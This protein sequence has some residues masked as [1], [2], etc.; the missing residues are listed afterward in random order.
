MVQKALILALLFAAIAAGVSCGNTKSH[1]LYA[2]LPAANEIVAFREDP[3]SGVLTELDGSPYSVGDG[4]HSIVIH[5]SG[6]FAYACNPG[7]AANNENDISLF[8][9]ASNGELTEVFPRTPLGSTVSLPQ[10]LVMDPAGA[11]LYVMNAGS[12]NISIFSI[13]SS[14]GAL[15]QVPNSPVNIGLTPL[16]MQVTSNGKLLYVTAVGTNITGEIVG[17]SV[18]AG[19]LTLV[20]VTPSGGL[21]PAGLVIDPAGAHLYAGNNAASSSSISIFD[22]GSTGSLTQVAGSPLNDSNYSSPIWMTFD[23]NGQYLYVA[24]EGS[25]NVTAYSINSTT[26]LPSAL[27]TTITTNAF[28]TES[29]PSFVTL[30]PGGEYLFVGNQLAP[31]GIQVFTVSSG[32]LTVIKDYPVGNTVSS[33]AVLK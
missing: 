11:Y 18:N 12:N 29:N 9:I 10:L 33:I 28:A 2:T 14:T 5:P 26:G 32:T 19:Q 25:N 4:V 16:N 7:I 8:T 15:T 20:G 21:N 22:I 30:D 1:Y 24:N 17:Y 13:D 27:T 3:N 31:A 6:Q 23:P